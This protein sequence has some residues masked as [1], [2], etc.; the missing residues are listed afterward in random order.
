MI[1]KLKKFEELREEWDRERFSLE[2][3]ERKLLAEARYQ[4]ALA[5]TPDDLL[6]DMRVDDLTDDEML[7]LTRWMKVNW[8]AQHPL[9]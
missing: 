6:L 7:S 9:S 8:K 5:L 3:A 1:R 4:A 2:L